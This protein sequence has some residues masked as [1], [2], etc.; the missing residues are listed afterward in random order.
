MGGAGPTADGSTS[1][2][3]MGGV[4]GKN[5]FSLGVNGETW[6]ATMLREGVLWLRWRDVGFSGMP[7]LSA[8][9]RGETMERRPRRGLGLRIELASE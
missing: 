6:T 9:C 3:D 4:L 1:F 7:R 8:G 2:L 5:P